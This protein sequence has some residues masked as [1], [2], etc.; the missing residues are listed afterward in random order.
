[1]PLDSYTEDARADITDEAHLLAVLDEIVEVIEQI[2]SELA[3]AIEDLERLTGE[4]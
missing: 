4:K 2:N 1:M 3:K